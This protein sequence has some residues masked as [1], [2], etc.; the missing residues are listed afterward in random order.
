MN[1]VVF[2][3]VEEQEYYV[4]IHDSVSVHRFLD[5]ITVIKLGTIILIKNVYRVR[6]QGR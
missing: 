2:D 3:I 1:N 6:F 4:T 5:T